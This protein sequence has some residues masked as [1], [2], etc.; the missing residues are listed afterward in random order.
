T[1]VSRTGTSARSGAL[2]PPKP[3]LTAPRTAGKPPT[4]PRTAGQPPEPPNGG[5]AAG[6]TQPPDPSR[7]E[8]RGR[9]GYR[10]VAR[11]DVRHTRR[12]GMPHAT[13]PR[14]I[15]PVRVA[16]GGPA[17]RSWLAPAALPELRW[18]VAAVAAAGPASAGPLLATAGGTI[19]GPDHPGG[20]GT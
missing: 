6:S 20:R 3:A 14:A 12:S 5:K 7:F 17:L 1:D 16:E 2:P 11:R 9:A 15:L 18:L 13:R 8:P 19:T 10:R 4:A